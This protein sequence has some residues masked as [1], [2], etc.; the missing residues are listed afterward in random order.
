[1]HFGVPLDGQIFLQRL[2]NAKFGTICSSIRRVVRLLDE[3]KQQPFKKPQPTP[4][5]PPVTERESIIML[6]PIDPDSR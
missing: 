2:N 1:V 5:A 6:T 3:P 4:Y